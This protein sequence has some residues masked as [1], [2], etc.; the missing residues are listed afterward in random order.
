MVTKKNHRNLVIF[1][2][3]CNFCNS[4]VG[5][6]IRH[7]KKALFSFAA[8]QTKIAQN[9]L[10]KYNID[11]EN[12]DGLILIQNNKIYKKTNA[13]LEIARGLSGL[14]AIFYIF[15][16]IPRVIRD[17]FYDLFA[18]KRYILFGQKD[19]CMIP[20]AELRARFLDG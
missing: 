8:S 20:T 19:A 11:R 12:V 1:D 17:Y 2:G 7:D 4:S 13:A 9:L 15:K 16:I 6:I 18:T 3:V 14:W 10:V 5:F